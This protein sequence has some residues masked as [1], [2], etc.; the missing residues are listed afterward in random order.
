MAL[1]NT[2]SKVFP[3]MAWMRQIRFSSLLI[4]HQST[5]TGRRR[6]EDGKHLRRCY[7]DLP[8]YGRHQVLCVGSSKRPC[9]RFKHNGSQSCGWTARRLVQSNWW[10]GSLR[11]NHRLMNFLLKQGFRS[12]FSE[13]NWRGS[14]WDFILCWRFWRFSC[15]WAYGRCSMRRVRRFLQFMMDGVDMARVLFTTG[16]I[17]FKLFD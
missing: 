1:I 9:D 6:F 5:R 2:F 17:Q 10:V 4:R 12:S 8:T 14:T 11:M 16:E 3:N 13:H 15:S 7:T